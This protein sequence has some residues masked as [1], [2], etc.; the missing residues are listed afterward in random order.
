MITSESSDDPKLQPPAG[1]G[2]LTETDADLGKQRRQTMKL[3]DV[4][5]TV[6]EYDGRK[7]VPFTWFCKKRSGEGDER[8]YAEL[9]KGYDDLENY[10]RVY[11]ESYIHELFTQDEARQLKDYLDSRYG[12]HATTTIT[13]VPLPVDNTS[14]GLERCLSGAPLT[15]TC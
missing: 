13:E 11:V 6:K 15:S 1:A 3:Y 12:P 4:T 10:L 7:D 9:I 14:W 8:R 5:S 2:G